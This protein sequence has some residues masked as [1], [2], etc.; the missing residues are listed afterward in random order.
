MLH[1]PTAKEPDE[2]RKCLTDAGLP[3]IFIPSRDSF[4]AVDEIPLLGTGKLDLKGA[5]ELARQ[6]TSGVE[7]SG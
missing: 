7:A 1:L 5:Q 6:L 2:L 3:N 4:I